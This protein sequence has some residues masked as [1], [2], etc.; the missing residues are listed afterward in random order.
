[1]NINDEIAIRDAVRYALGQTAIGIRVFPKEYWERK[2]VAKIVRDELRLYEST[3]AITVFD[4]DEAVKE[5]ISVC[6]GGEA[7][8]S[9]D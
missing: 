8:A 3:G 9:S 6:K 5:M 2:D 4:M 1:M 7:D